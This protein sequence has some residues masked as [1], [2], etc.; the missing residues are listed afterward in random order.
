MAANPALPGDTVVVRDQYWTIAGS[1]SFEHCTLL[2]L[3]GRGPG[4]AGRRLRAIAPFDRVHASPE[5]RPKLRKRHTVL[6]AALGAI[7]HEQRAIDLWT[8]ADARLDLLAYQLEPALAVLGGATRV[9]LADGVG[10]GKTIQ[11]G[12]LLAELRARSLVDRALIICPAGLRQTWAAELRARFG[13]DAAV[14]DNAAIAIGSRDWPEDINPWAAH[15]V[16]I[17]S[18]DLVKRPDVLAAV[19]AVG[20]DLVIADE[21]HHLTPASDRCHAVNRLGSQAPWLVLVSATPHSGDPTAF[22]CLSAVGSLGERLVIFRRGRGDLG[23]PDNRRERLMGVT[24]TPDEAWLLRAVDQYANEIW[25]ARGQSDRAVR[26]VAITLARR[27]ASSAAALERTLSRRRALLADAAPPAPRQGSLPWEEVDDD[28]G[29]E[30]DERLARPGL[31]S[32]EAERRRLDE[33]IALARRTSARSSKLC[34]LQRLLTRAREA[35]VVFTEYRDTLQAAADRLAPLLRIGSIHGGVPAPMRDKVLRQFEQGELDVLLATDTAGEGLNLHRRCRLVIDLELPWSPLRLEQR[36]GRVDRLGQ[37]RRVH[38]VH[39]LHREAVE[40]RVWT[41]LEGR[42]RLAEQAL[43]GASPSTEDDMGRAVFDGVPLPSTRVPLVSSVRIGAADAE[44]TRVADLRR[45]RGQA[46]APSDRAV[47]ARPRAAQRGVPGAVALYESVQVGSGGG[48]I[49]RRLHARAVGLAG[50][51]TLAAWQG[52]VFA[53]HEVT[54]VGGED[55][56]LL[57]PMRDAVRARI[58]AARRRL[59]SPPRPHQAALFD[60]RAERAASTRREVAAHVD[61]V[62]ARRAA[63]LDLDHLPSS[64]PRLVAVWPL[65]FKT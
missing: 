12:L 11:A 48:L 3:E 19:E 14:L 57:R 5:G 35:A 10:L 8:A 23:L 65:P 49:A 37:A 46:S 4:N 20:F 38:A 36:V 21:A 17:A 16:V 60:R 51:R 58:D 53:M 28:D 47:Y 2:T 13:I 62:L 45:W 43:G 56:S 34:R 54:D 40:G 31:A 9:L 30:R 39:L 55:L 64:R 61:A 32:V 29:D 24:P 63:A 25:H 7:A 50:V 41:H 42:R 44:K 6:R 27:A 1:E 18:I 15:P 59:S 26:L 22:A 33:L 52:V